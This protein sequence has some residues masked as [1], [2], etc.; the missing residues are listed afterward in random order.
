MIPDF[1]HNIIITGVRP[2]DE[3]ALE[4]ESSYRLSCYSFNICKVQCDSSLRATRKI[5]LAMHRAML[6]HLLYVMQLLTNVHPLLFCQGFRITKLGIYQYIFLEII[7]Q[8]SKIKPVCSSP[9]ALL[10]LVC[11]NTKNVL[12]TASAVGIKATHSIYNWRIMDSSSDLKWVS[13]K[14]LRTL[15]L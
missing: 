4:S 13:Y 6:N 12:Q 7:E 11:A 5:E 14:S 10:L 8:N 15:L 9:R 1:S 3:R 2:E